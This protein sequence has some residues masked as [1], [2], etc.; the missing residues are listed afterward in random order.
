MPPPSR[1]Q[2]PPRRV[3]PRPFPTSPHRDETCPLGRRATTIVS[4]LTTVDPPTLS[5]AQRPTATAAETRLFARVAD[6]SPSSDASASLDAATSP[7]LR[8]HLR[9]HLRDDHAVAIRDG[10]TDAETAACDA[11][12]AAARARRVV[13][14]PRPRRGR[15]R[16]RRRH[17]PRH[18]RRLR[19][20]PTTRRR[21]DRVQQASRPHPRRARGG[22][23]P[24]AVP[25]PRG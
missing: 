10:R 12:L 7:D 25:T 19:H 9:D 18:T 20:P 13:L 4:T 2:P 14:D 24:P 15:R 5:H 21:V 11:R 6:R 3:R 16:R 8:D 1:R 22:P 23:E 17:P